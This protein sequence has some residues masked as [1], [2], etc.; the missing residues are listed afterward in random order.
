M[1]DVATD[2]FRTVGPADAIPN[3]FVVPYYLD[4]RKLRISVAR[5]GD[6]LYAFDDLCPCADRAC[7]LSGGLLTGKTIMCQCHG[8]R[9]DI[10]SGAVVNGPAT[11]ALNVYEAREVD[12]DVQ[13]RV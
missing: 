8:S 2:A 1:T 4:D 9:F 5:V 11:D 7:P 13:I 6:H 12:G 3:D 10:V